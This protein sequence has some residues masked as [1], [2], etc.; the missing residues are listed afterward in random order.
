MLPVAA[1]D[2]HRLLKQLHLEALPPGVRV[3]VAPLVDVHYGEDV[4]ESDVET[5]LVTVI[6]PE[7][8]VI[9]APLIVAL[10]PSL[11]PHKIDQMH[12]KH[13]PR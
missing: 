8:A 11:K 5:C 13:K 2:G 7:G 12:D 9:G 4:N 6:G 1:N 10:P 3:E